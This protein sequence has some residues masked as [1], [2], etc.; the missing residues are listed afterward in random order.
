M[1]TIKK[2]DM[3]VH[4][5]LE[6][7]P[8]RLRGETWPTADELRSIYDLY[9]IEKGVEMARLA[10][11]RSHDPITN[12]DAEKLAR[13]FPGTIGWWF[14]Y[15]D[16]RMGTNSPG[17]DLSYYLDYYKDHGARG[18]GEIQAGID[19]DDPR[20]MNLFHHIEKSGLPVTIHFGVQGEGCGP[21]DDAGLPRL[22]RV[23]EE[24][25]KLTV[26]G[27]AAPFWAEISGD[28]DPAKRNSYVDGP[29][30]EGNIAK[31]LR[32]YPNLYCDLSAGSGYNALSRDLDYT[33]K[34]FRE[35][36]ERLVY[37][38]DIRQPSDRDGKLIK[39]GAL[40][41]EAFKNGVIDETQYANIV[42]QNALRLLSGESRL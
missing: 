24:F 33:Y 25:P 30:T 38:T 11:E 36:H 14:C 26:L 22:R 3:H 31:M 42:R 40:I 13:L 34:F 2:I 20:Y 9:G 35:F 37:A 29:V 12:R 21:W 4:C 15:M 32:K 7:G 5:C 10:P 39:T 19:L 1:E 17:D 16:P 23:L 27:H 8:E 41:D 18:V 6:K 28:V